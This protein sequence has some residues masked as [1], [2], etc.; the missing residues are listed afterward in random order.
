MKIS[1]N[2]L[3]D[4]IPD[5]PAEPVNILSEKMISI[6][7]DIEGIEDESIIFD[8]FVVGE[9][10]EKDKHPD[11]D[12]LSLCKVNTGNQILSIV[13]GAPNV[14]KGQKVCVA[15]IGAVIPNG[16][17]EIKKSKIRGELSEGM[18]CSE[19][20]LNM[21]EN[22]DGILV[23]DPDAL[24]GEKFSDHI[25][26]NDLVFD[27]GITA[28]RGD[29]Y[30]YFGVAREVAAMYDKK[31][32][33]PKAEVKESDVPTKDLIKIT[34]EDTAL[35]R[36]FTGRVIKNVETKESP[37]WLKKKL[38]AIGL[39]PKNNIVDITNFVMFE[40]GQPLHAFD[41]DKIRGKEI[42]VKTAKEGD[43]FTTLDSKERTLNSG[44]LMICDS[45]GY[46][47]IAGVMGGKDSEISESTKNI[48]I[49]VTNV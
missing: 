41:Y 14:A 12:K 34:I 44:S 48:L 13:C 2:W 16:N 15:M 39:K 22:H 1:L 4:Y 29:L 38:N 24:P 31:I 40:T 18:I 10:I 21:S 30:S 11:A 47:G 8:K 37:D 28:N 42:I 26:A 35:C 5:L 20:E 32:S 49:K 6:G 27:I 43:K 25:K 17:F 45:E 23:L 7:L 33:M 19:K 36:R 3:K 46:T 9:V